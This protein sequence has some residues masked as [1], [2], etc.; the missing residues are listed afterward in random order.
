MIIGIAVHD[1]VTEYYEL[2]LSQSVRICKSR[3]DG[4]DLAQE[5]C[6]K[7]I[8][9]SA[10]DKE[11]LIQHPRSYINSMVRNAFLDIYR[12]SSESKQRK[13]STPLQ[14]TIEPVD[15]APEITLDSLD[16]AIRSL[17]HE[18]QLV[19]SLYATTP[20]INE[21]SRKTEIAYTTLER[22]IKRIKTKIK[23]KTHD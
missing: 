7:L 18:E 12:R 13:L 10:S 3:A 5:V 20:N 2:I 21:L 16:E 6:I 14:Y 9:M 19:W 1:L 22:M 8:N 23:A 15:E 17:N 11:H 4:Q